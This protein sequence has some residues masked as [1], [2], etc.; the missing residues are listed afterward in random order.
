VKMLL[1][2]GADPDPRDAEGRTALS[3]A[4]QRGYTSTVDLLLQSGASTETRSNI[5]GRTPLL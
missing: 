2:K 4:A 3:W 5:N 1:D